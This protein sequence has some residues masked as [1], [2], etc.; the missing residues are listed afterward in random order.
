M[1]FVCYK[2]PHLD[3]DTACDPRSRCL[4]SNALGRERRLRD[5][6][7]DCLQRKYSPRGCAGLSG[8]EADSHGQLKIDED[9]GEDQRTSLQSKR[10]R[11]DI[12]NGSKNLLYYSGAG[13]RWIGLG[14]IV[15]N[16]T[17]HT[18]QKCGGRGLIGLFGDFRRRKNDKSC[19]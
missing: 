10:R 6:I 16:L 9:R 14:C 15:R 19:S 11:E 7:P 2:T 17:P 1:S 3:A 8:G 13:R 4:R 12:L 5:I 18:I